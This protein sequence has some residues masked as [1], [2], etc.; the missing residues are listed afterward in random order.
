MI[1]RA[2]YFKYFLG[3]GPVVKNGYG[4]GYNIQEEQLGCVISNYKNE[5]N[6]KEFIDCLRKS[7]DDLIDVIQA[8]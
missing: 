1:F 5:T 3:F 7:Y 8:K 2:I 4:V 6:G